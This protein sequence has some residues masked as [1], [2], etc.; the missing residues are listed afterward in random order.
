MAG[1]RV[2]EQRKVESLKIMQETEAKRIKINELLEYIE[3]RLTE[4]EEEREELLAYQQLDKER[5]C[6]EYTIYAREQ[7][8]ANQY[9][10][11]L[12]EYRRDDMESAQQRLQALAEQ[13][14]LVENLEVDIQSSQSHLELLQMEKEQ[15]LKDK[16]AYLKTKTQLE[17]CLSDLTESDVKNQNVKNSLEKKLKKLDSDIQKKEDALSQLLPEFKEKMTQEHNLQSNIELLKVEKESLMAKQGRWARFKT[18]HDR[19]EWLKTELET[20]KNVYQQQK[21]QVKELEND[22]QKLK[23]EDLRNEEEIDQIKNQLIQNKTEL[24]SVQL[25]YE[26]VR[27]QRNQLDEERK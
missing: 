13:T 21:S 20:L 17:L 1:T 8:E 3:E 15:L 2:Y 19:D 9:L 7:D 24:D 5:R 12:E 4:L 27:T 26:A 25:Q 11:E 22:L 23:T 6:L 10:E 18:Q 16:E 14:N